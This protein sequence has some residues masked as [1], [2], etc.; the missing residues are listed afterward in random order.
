MGA[1]AMQLKSFS[2]RHIHSPATTQGVAQ[3]KVIQRY[4]MAN[5]YQITDDGRYRLNPAEPTVLFVRQGARGPHPAN[6]FHI[7]G[8]QNI[9]NARQEQITFQRYESRSLLG[10]PL[11]I[12]SPPIRLP[13]NSWHRVVTFS[14]A[15]YNG[16]NDCGM[17]ATGVLRDNPAWGITRQQQVF[18]APGFW[19]PYSTTGDSHLGLRPVATSQNDKK[20]KPRVGQALTINPPPN[21]VSGL[22]GTSKYPFRSNFHVA[23]TV[24]TAGSDYI[25]SEADAGHYG[26]AKPYWKISGSKKA[27]QSWHEKYNDTFKDSS[28]KRAQAGLNPNQV[29]PS[30][31][32]RQ[33]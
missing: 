12:A 30:T 19:M 16:P 20:L 2:F 5:N 23:P 15:P 3:A 29:W 28:A 11:P 17:Y 33:V 18:I 27:G 24:I 14:Y 22:F 13:D 26:R 10:P 9:A 8:A 32:L 6:F 25:T 4:S 1:K 7:T 21:S 31:H